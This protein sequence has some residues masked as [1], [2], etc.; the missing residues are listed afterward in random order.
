MDDIICLHEGTEDAIAP[1]WLPYISPLNLT[2]LAEADG[3][4]SNLPQAYLIS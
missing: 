1:S 4:F 3:K 2:N